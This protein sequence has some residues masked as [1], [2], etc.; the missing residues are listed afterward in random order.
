MRLS[1]EAD[2]IRFHCTR[3]RY[4]HELHHIQR[5]RH[6]AAEVGRGLVDER[7]QGSGRIIETATTES[8]EEAQ[9]PVSPSQADDRYKNC[10]PET[11]SE[12][13]QFRDSVRP[14]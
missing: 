13:R 5:V 2:L 12:T 9:A 3:P 1:G 14:L 11:S 7:R 4:S 10:F 6:L 8:E